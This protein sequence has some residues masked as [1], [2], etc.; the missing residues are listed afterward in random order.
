MNNKN[1]ELMNA[2]VVLSWI[3]L[4]FSAIAVSVAFACICFAM[5]PMGAIMADTAIIGG[6]DGP[7]SI[8]LSGTLGFGGI[9]MAFAVIA[10]IVALA[11]KICAVVFATKAKNHN[12]RGYLLV[13]S[14]LNA[15][16][17]LSGDVI[18]I[19]GA[20]CGFILY[21]DMGNQEMGDDVKVEEYPDNTY[22]M[23]R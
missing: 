9:M 5:L 14:I 4:V 3:S 17:L 23:K 18:A 6:A 16:G 10:L 8:A 12:S 21:S 7:T 13:A 15:I 2:V 19:A 20:I 22:G 1:K 11:M